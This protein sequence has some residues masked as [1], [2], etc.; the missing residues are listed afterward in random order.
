MDIM[1][2]H[3]WCKP[4]HINLEIITYSKNIVGYLPNHL[5]YMDKMGYSWYSIFCPYPSPQVFP[6]A[7]PEALHRAAL[8]H[9]LSVP[10]AQH[11]AQQMQR[12]KPLPLPQLNEPLT[13]AF[14]ARGDAM[15]Y[16][17]LQLSWWLMVIYNGIFSGHD[18]LPK[19]ELSWFY[20]CKNC[21]RTVG[22]ILDIS[23]CIKLVHAVYKPTNMTGGHNIVVGEIGGLQLGWL[24]WVFVV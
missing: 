15:W 3:F 13:G 11:A 12:Q 18:E 22:F 24:L 17:R 8:R 7:N 10:A 5:T 4:L 19:F 23:K 9:G 21:Y 16:P 20:N 6:G 2:H 1:D 14:F